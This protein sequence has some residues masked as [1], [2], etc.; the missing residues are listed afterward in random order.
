MAP[1]KAA[2]TGNKFASVTPQELV[3]HDLSQ[4]SGGPQ[5]LQRYLAAGHAVDELDPQGQSSLR[6]ACRA[7]GA[8]SAVKALLHAGADPNL[9]SPDGFTPLMMAS[10]VDI[11]VYPLDNGADTERMSS[12]G[13]AVL[14]AACI[15]GGLPVVRLLLKR[16]AHDQILKRNDSGHTA[17]SAAI[18]L[19]DESLALLLLQ[20]LFAQPGFDVNHT[21]SWPAADQPLLPAAATAGMLKLTEAALKQGAAV[22]E[23]APDGYTGLMNAVANSHATVAGVLCRAGARMHGWSVESKLATSALDVAVTLK[24]L[25][26]VRQLLACGAD[27]NAV[28]EQAQQLVLQAIAQ[29]DILEALLSAGAVLTP[30]QQYRCLTAASSRL[31]DTAAARTT[32]LLLP[33]CSSFDVADPNSKNTALMQAIIHGKLLVAR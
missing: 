24:D 8:L 16:V 25:P 28:C 27:V 23:A 33:H 18:S 31:E 19:G 32:T 20:H 14:K 13:S 22:D 21:T 5:A 7:G 26:M 2:H 11:A 12:N 1:R 10:S 3:V 15:Y 6:L 29:Y 30:A 17:L 4:K 9:S